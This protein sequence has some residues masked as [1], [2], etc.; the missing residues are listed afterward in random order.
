MI[1]ANFLF[2]IIA[3]AVYALAPTVGNP[4]IAYPFNIYGLFLSFLGFWQYNRFRFTTLRARLD[5]DQITIYNAK[6]LYM[7]LISRNIAIGLGL[8]ILGVYLFDLKKLLTQIPV[9]GNLEIFSNSIGV[10]VFLCHLMAVWYWAFQSMGDVLSIGKSYQSYIWS[11]I[12][13]NLAIVVPW[14]IFMAASDLFQLEQIPLLAQV[15]ILA[16]FMVLMAIL[17]PLIVVRLWDCHPLPDSELKEEIEAYCQS[18]G[19]KFKGIMSWNALNRSLVTAGVIGLIYPYRY[20]MITPE[21]MRILDK[22]ELMAV[23]SHEV[24]HVKNRHLLYYLLFFLGFLVVGVSS[25]LWINSFLNSPVG[26]TYILSTNATIQSIVQVIVTLSMFVLYFRFVFGFYIRNFERQADIYCFQSGIDPSHM[27]TSFMKLGVQMGDDG[28]KPNWHHY[29]I[30]QR[31]EF[32]KKCQESPGYISRHN[33]RVRRSISGFIAAMIIFSVVTLYPIGFSTSQ[34]INYNHWEK[35]LHNR[36]QAEPD[37]FRWYTMLGMVSYQ[38]E[39]WAQVKDA[40]ETSIKLNN[41]QPG[42]LNNLAWFYLKCPEEPLLDPK[43]ALK[44][45]EQAIRMEQSPHIFDTLA[46]AYFQN[47]KFKEA[48]LAAKKALAT[49]NENF[50]YYKDQLDKMTKYYRKLDSTIEI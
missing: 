5:D 22:D 23:V 27:V 17:A 6:R 4:N 32:I 42:V 2:F 36:I 18:Q 41:R 13:F 3:I 39:K 26:L 21:L 31:I 29:N 12:K 7:Q 44:L 35:A 40:Y 25:D 10:L 43:R 38:L 15:G 24:G 49:A 1:Y 11:N 16:I 14:L 19:V 34:E 20:L 48:Y 45:A 28:K 30:S 47:S 9:L 33:K 37:E 50:Q 8:F 46:E